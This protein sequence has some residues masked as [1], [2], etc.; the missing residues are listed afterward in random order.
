MGEQRLTVD[1]C[2]LTVS[3]PGSGLCG[4]ETARAKWDEYLKMMHGPRVEV[5]VNVCKLW[6]W[7]KK[8][9][10]RRRENDRKGNYESNYEKT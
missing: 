6:G 3:E 2:R 9:F 10:S 7:V 1:G 4:R 5:K 8:S